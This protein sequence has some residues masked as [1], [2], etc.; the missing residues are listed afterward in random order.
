MNVD[1]GG[2]ILCFFSKFILFHLPE[3][4]CHSMVVS[5]KYF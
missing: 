2:N 1:S 5:Q 4:Y 3:Q